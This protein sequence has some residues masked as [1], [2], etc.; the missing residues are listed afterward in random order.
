MSMESRAQVSNGLVE[1]FLAT[2]AELVTF[3][4]GCSDADWN[5]ECPGE[6]WTVGVVL[7]HCVWGYEVSDGWLSLMRRG[8]AI[9][10]SPEEHSANNARMAAARAA[11]TRAEV[12]DLASANAAAHVQVLRG[13]TEEE[14]DREVPFGPAGGIPMAVRRMAGNTNHVRH[15]LGSAR[16]AV[17]PAS[18]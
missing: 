4:E 12:L 15:H 8:E 17:A 9:P 13:L 6:G 10:T 5:T 3:I 16:A 7:H 18:A 14:L 1:P 2:H 11:V